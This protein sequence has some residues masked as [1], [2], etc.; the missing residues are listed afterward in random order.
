MELRSF[1]ITCQ[2][3]LGEFSMQWHPGNNNMTDYYIQNVDGKYH[4][5]VCPWYVHGHN[6]PEYLP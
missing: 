2:V 3:I 6:L 5:E 1:W 4:L